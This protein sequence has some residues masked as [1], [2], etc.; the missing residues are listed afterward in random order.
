MIVSSLSLWVLWKA[1]CSKLYNDEDIHVVDQ[2][3]SFWNLLVHSVKGEYDRYKGYGNTAIQKRKRLRRVWLAIP[4]ML[5]AGME[6]R[7]NYVPPRWLFPPPVPFL[8]QT[9]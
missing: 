4:I 1:R 2:V 9:T 5:D 3:K 6:V 8:W 7:W